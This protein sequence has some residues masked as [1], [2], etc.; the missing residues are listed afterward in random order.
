MLKIHQSPLAIDGQPLPSETTLGKLQIHLPR[1][2]DILP[3]RA[4]VDGDP[5][6]NFQELR[7]GVAFRKLDLVLSVV[8]LLSA[9]L[10]TNLPRMVNPSQ[11]QVTSLQCYDFGHIPS[12]CG[13]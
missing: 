2:S 1:C 7:L 5:W 4:M 3:F 6:I 11:A 12:Y 8:E 13:Q 10:A 9:A